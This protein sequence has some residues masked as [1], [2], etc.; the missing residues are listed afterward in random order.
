MATDSPVEGRATGLTGRRREC[1]VLDRVDRLPV[2]Q[3]DALRTGFG[4]SAGPAPDRFLVGLAVLSLLS[5][6]AEEQPL[7]CLVDDEHWLDCASA[8]VLGFVARRLAAI[9]IPTASRSPAEAG[10]LESTAIS[11]GPFG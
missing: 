10:P 11:P 5:D 7:V 9:D 1:D 2:P 4:L 3:R 8:Q 6:A